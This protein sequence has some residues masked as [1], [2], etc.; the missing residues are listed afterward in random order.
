MLDGLYRQINDG[1]ET[2]KGRV[3]L[4]LLA[5][6]E[7]T[8]FPVTIELFVAPLMAT[9]RRP[10]L[11]AHIILIGT[12]IGA[13]L[14]YLLGALIEPT[15]EPALAQLGWLEQ[16]NSFKVDLEKNGFWVMF[17]VG[18]TPFP[19]Q[20]GT[21]GAGAIGYSLPLFVMAVILSRAI[22]YYAVAGL[23][24]YFGRA[25][26]T[27]I[28]QYGTLILFVGTAVLLTGWLLYEIIAPRLL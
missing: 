5:I 21:V 8:I 10:F 16:F 22:R 20:I 19:F 24:W 13:L 11:I 25:A 26:R 7:C 2:L 3:L 9:S 14:G 23:A 28:E 17:L 27:W 1:V 6:L 15:I 4:C 12:V 18:L